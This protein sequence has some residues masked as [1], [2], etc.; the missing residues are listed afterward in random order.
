MTGFVRP[1]KNYDS[2]DA[3]IEAIHNDINVAKTK[4]QAEQHQIL[5]NH[6]FFQGD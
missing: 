4:L 6:E 2:L 5:K 1:E 3:L